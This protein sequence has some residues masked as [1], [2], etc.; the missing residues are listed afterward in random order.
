MLQ[1]RGE[2]SL[3]E[4]LIWGWTHQFNSSERSGSFGYLHAGSLCYH[5]A[6]LMNLHDYLSRPGALTVTELR[7]LIGAKSD[8]QVR[9]WRHKY[10]DRVPSPEN[11]AA[12]EKATAGKVTCEDLRKDVNWTRIPDASWPWHRKGRPLLDVTKAVA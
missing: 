6:G 10:A 5:N 11:C 2:P 9:Q 3:S 1:E 4:L 8:A 12:I 7:R